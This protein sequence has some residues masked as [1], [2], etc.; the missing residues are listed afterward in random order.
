[1]D[2]CIAILLKILLCFDL[3]YPISTDDILC[4]EGVAKALL[5]NVQHESW[6][7]DVYGTIIPLSQ[8]HILI[9]LSVLIK[10][11]GPY[12]C[13]VGSLK[14]NMPINKQLSHNRWYTGT[15]DIA[16]AT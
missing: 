16:V 3:C 13:I 6:F 12:D 9:S 8:C 14:H 5:T 7:I 1:M 2:M 11:T 15:P 10:S 4:A